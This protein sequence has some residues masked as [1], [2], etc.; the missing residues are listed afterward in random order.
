MTNQSEDL[1]KMLVESI[2]DEQHGYE[3]YEHMAELEEAAGNHHCAGVLRDIAHEEHT[4]R[5][6]LEEMLHGE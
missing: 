6:L 4:H 2:A 5:M 3:H 1:T